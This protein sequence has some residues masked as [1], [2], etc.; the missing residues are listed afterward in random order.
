MSIKIS[1]ELKDLTKDCS[2]KDLLRWLE[3]LY[4]DREALLKER[5]RLLEEAYG[6]K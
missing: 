1:K 2:R 4:R 5:D 6:T 3:I